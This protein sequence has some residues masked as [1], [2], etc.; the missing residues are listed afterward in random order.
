MLLEKPV[1][2]TDYSGTKDFINQ[3]TG[4]PVNYQLIPVKKNQYPFWQNQTWAEPDINHAAWLMR[5]MIADETKTKKIAK[6]GKQKIL[7]DYSLKAIGKIYK[8]R[9]DH[10]SSLI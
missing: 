7:T 6:Q 3:G 9:L 1:I 10:L 4:F 2:A 5:N 8:K